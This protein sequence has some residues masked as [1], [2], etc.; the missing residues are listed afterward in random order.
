MLIALAT[1][2][3]IKDASQIEHT[4]HKSQNINKKIKAVGIESP[5]IISPRKTN[6]IV[7]FIIKFLSSSFC[8]QH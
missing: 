2:R 7:V 8:L 5:N 1:N 4:L 6:S 3:H